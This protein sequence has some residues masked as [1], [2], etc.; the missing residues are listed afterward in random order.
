MVAHSSE[1]P[2]RASFTDSQMS[3]PKTQTGFGII[4]GQKLIA[5]FDDL[6]V[7]EPGPGEVLLK[8]E[9]AGLCR[10][11]LHILIIQ[12]PRLPEKMVMGHEICGSVAKAGS[13]IENDPRYQV[14]KRFAMLIADACGTCENCRSGRD[15]MCTIN[16]DRAYGLSQDGGFQE[17]LLVK[18][19]RSLLPIADNVSFEAAASATD[20]ILTPYHAIMKVK[21]VLSPTTKVLVLG[22]GG[23]GLNAIQILKTFGC[24]IVCVDK[25]AGNEKIAKEFGATDFFTDP[26]EIDHDSETFDVCFD[27]VGNQTT[28]E[29]C[30]EF[31]KS[32]GKIVMVGLGKMTLTIPNY[33]LAR[34]EVQI[35]FNFG[36]N[37]KDQTEVLQWIS[38]GILQPVVTTAPLS[39]LPA[40]MAKLAK[41]EVV[42]RV[43]FK[44]KL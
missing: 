3:L 12:D 7:P 35:I 23:L 22:A 38:E 28:V 8:I 44:P 4:Y 31:V 16:V 1:F 29:A 26:D 11:D 6:P 41:G 33:D 37:S 40:Y 5:R 39:D 13:A 19:V 2:A 21:D 14:G 9:A 17:Y 36:G 43:V 27:F 15:N 34:R 30:V 18:N 32:G 25:K 24:K 10:S 20:A 42:G